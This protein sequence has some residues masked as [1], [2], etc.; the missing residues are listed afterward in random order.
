V[1]EH[2]EHGKGN[3][4]A[5]CMK[6]AI[7]EKYGPSVGLPTA[8]MDL[9]SDELAPNATESTAYLTVADIRRV[10]EWFKKNPPNVKWAL[11]QR[12]IFEANHRER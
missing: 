7:L 2:I 11:Y 5:A 3:P 10:V 12:E 1:S 6:E 8:P 9:P 4:C